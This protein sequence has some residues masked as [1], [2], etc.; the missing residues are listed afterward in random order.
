MNA[1]PLSLALLLV[2]CSDVVTSHYPTVVE[3]R[4]DGL[5]DRGWL[6]DVLPPSAR[7]IEVSN[8]LDINTS[9]GEFWFDAP[10]YGAMVA[11]LTPQQVAGEKENEREYQPYVYSAE[12]YRWIFS[13]NQVKGHCRYEMR[14]SRSDG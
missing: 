11:K 6:P 1:L 12:G 2:A 14:P 5:F 8:N 3:A 9:V 10:E 7:D 4:R 13:C